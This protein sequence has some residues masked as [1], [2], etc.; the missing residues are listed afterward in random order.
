MVRMLPP[1]V[2]LRVGAIQFSTTLEEKH[3]ADVACWHTDGLKHLVAFVYWNGDDFD[4]KTIGTR[5]WELC[6]EDQAFVWALA[7]E[8]IAMMKRL[9]SLAALSS[10]A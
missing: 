4:L 2:N 10:K 5:P 6:E 3:V 1:Y 8:G 7:H 9:R